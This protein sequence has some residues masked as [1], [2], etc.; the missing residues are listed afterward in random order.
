MTRVKRGFVAKRR[1]KKILDRTEGFIGSS[2]TLYRTANERCIKALTY[3]S[4]DRK[5]K[6]RE[7]RSLWI[8]RLNAATNEK[9]VNYSKFI[10]ACK[11][12]NILLNRKILSQIAIRDQDSFA[13]VIEFTN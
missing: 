4:R 5:V 11:N 6:K 10:A 3:S 9:G 2:S 1:R 13:K 8:T 12:K 7:Y